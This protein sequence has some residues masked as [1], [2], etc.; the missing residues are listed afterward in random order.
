MLGE[1]SQI[2]RVS[3]SNR[4]TIADRLLCVKST[5]KQRDKGAETRSPLQIRPASESEKGNGCNDIQN[6][7]VSGGVQCCLH[8]F[9]HTAVTEHSLHVEAGVTAAT[10]ESSGISQAR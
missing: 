8:P 6:A 4:E 7:G 9:I 5:A 1:L 2:G 3:R 10:W